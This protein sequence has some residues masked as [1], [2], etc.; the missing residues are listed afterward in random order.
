MHQGSAWAIGTGGITHA[1][2]SEAGGA[3]VINFATYVGAISPA[4][5]AVAQTD[6]GVA[7]KVDTGE[8]QRYT[9]QVPLGVDTMAFSP[10]G[11]LLAVADKAGHIQ[12]VQAATGT[13]VRTLQAETAVMAL[14]F[15]DDGA[16]I[17]GYGDDGMIHIWAVSDGTLIGRLA[18]APAETKVASSIHQ[19]TEF[20][21]TPDK[22]L[23]IVFDAGSVRFYR[24]ADGHLT[25]QIAV[26]ASTIAIGPR[27][28]LLGLVHD[29]RVELWGVR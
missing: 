3:G 2:N 14:A 28:R 1:W 20:I 7:L 15:S 10:D 5:K 22:T 17:G 23:L 18:D 29:G 25:H 11:M 8:S 24:V 13:I 19:Q 9:L 27:Q 26:S 6:D 12:L 4:T 16:L 21:F